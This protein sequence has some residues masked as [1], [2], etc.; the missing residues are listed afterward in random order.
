[1]SWR[2]EKSKLKRPIYL[3]LAQQ[4]EDDIKKGYIVP[5]TKLPPQRELA[6][7]LDINFTTIT[8]VYKLCE[9]QGLI[10]AITGRGTFVSQ[11]AAHNATISSEDVSQNSLIDLGFI[12]PFEQCN[13]MVYNTVQDVLNKQ[14]FEKLL[15]YYQPLGM[16][17]QLMAGCNWMEQLGV[18]VDPNNIAV[19]SGAQNGLAI[20][21][22]ALFSPGDY[23]AVDRFI[24]AN[25]I[26]LAKLYQLRLIPIKNDEQGMLPSELQT[27]CKSINLKGI[28]LMP[29]CSN[30]TTILMSEYRKKELAKIIENNQLITIEDDILAFLSPG[31]VSE[32]EGSLSRHLSSRYIYLCGTSKSICAGLRVAYLSFSKDLKEMLTQAIFKI[33]IKTSSL[34]AEIIS[35]LI[36]NGTAEKI[37]AKK[38]KLSND[39]NLIF[40]LIFSK[41]K[42]FEHPLS[43]FRWL[44]IASDKN[45]NIIEEKFKEN[46][47]QVFH[48][49][50]FLCGYANEQR[51]LRISLSTVGSPSELKQGLAILKNTIS[52]I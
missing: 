20:I 18:H 31:V 42:K 17:H 35:E 40:N 38:R 39:A 41:P 49:D 8:R 21:L 37:V 45:G 16:P 6:D 44:P 5:G 46:G 36:L 43:L 47:I 2:P 33:N 48:S 26:E 23:I 28:Y 11:Y 25:F 50:R 24:Y 3:S 22:S 51:Y 14:H 32:Y 30:P 34:D 29:S 12:A 9:Q 52:K 19:V 1:M 13:S 27:Q 10:H 4:L 7:F 15:S